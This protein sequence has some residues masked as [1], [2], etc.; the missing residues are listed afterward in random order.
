MTSYTLKYLLER[1]AANAQA[2]TE[3]KNNIAEI[4]DE[5]EKIVGDTRRRAM[6]AKKQDTGTVHFEME[7][8]DVKAV[9]GKN[10]DWDQEALETAWD[11]IAASAED[12]RDYLKRKFEISE[13]AYK[14][15]PKSI[16]A[17]FA[18]ARTV[19]PGKTKYEFTERTET[20][21]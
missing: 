9:T 1:K 18:P 19:N 2:L 11:T 8:F 15:W 12:P 10:V 5:I 16:K 21:A 6:L 7:G 3:A 17:H 4:D 13:A 14:A 20:T